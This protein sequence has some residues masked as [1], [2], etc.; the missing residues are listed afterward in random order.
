MQTETTLPVFLVGFPAGA[1]A[2]IVNRRRLLLATQ[3]LILVA[4]AALSVLAHLGTRAAAGCLPGR[5]PGRD[6]HRQP[7]LGSACGSPG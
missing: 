4:A 3:G 1:L 2:D 6:R 7:A 5:L